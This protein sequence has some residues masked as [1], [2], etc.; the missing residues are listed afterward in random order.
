MQ[1]PK[2]TKAFLLVIHLNT[3]NLPVMPG[4]E[5]LD[6]GL[7]PSDDCSTLLERDPSTSI[8]A[9]SMSSQVPPI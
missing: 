5:G 2:I 6:K 8:S 7:V 9:S 1:L 3:C 4:L